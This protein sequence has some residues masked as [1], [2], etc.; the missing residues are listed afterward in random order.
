MPGVWLSRRHSSFIDQVCRMQQWSLDWQCIAPLSGQ[1]VCVELSECGCWCWTVQLQCRH[2]YAATGARPWQPLEPMLW[3]DSSPPTPLDKGPFSTSAESKLWAYGCLP[4][5]CW[6]PEH[7]DTC[8]CAGECAPPVGRTAVVGP[9]GV[10]ARLLVVLCCVHSLLAVIGRA[11]G[12]VYVLVVHCITLLS[13][14]LA[15]HAP[16]CAWSAGCLLYAMDIL[17][18]VHTGPA[19]REAQRGMAIRLLSMRLLVLAV[20]HRSTVLEL[21]LHTPVLAQERMRAGLCTWGHPL[22]SGSCC[23]QQLILLICMDT[24]GNA[25]CTS[26]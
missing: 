2:C 13:R 19:A 6:P 18:H 25:P 26:W 17:Q 9:Q 8:W 11:S 22:G 23:R 1:C 3:Q 24:L 5:G 12:P 21:Q 20:V 4:S 7:P 14:A 15:Q 10:C 16:A